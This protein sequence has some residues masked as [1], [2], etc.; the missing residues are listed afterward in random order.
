MENSKNALSNLM[1]LLLADNAQIAWLEPYSCSCTLFDLLFILLLHLFPIRTPVKLVKQLKPLIIIVLR[2]WLLVRVLL[3]LRFG[4]KIRNTPFIKWLSAVMERHG[5]YT[6]V[7][8]SS[9]NCV[10]WW[11]YQSFNKYYVLLTCVKFYLKKA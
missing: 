2:L 11:E 4:R 10:I 5:F 1:G 8:M 9:A 7:T 6:V 3:V